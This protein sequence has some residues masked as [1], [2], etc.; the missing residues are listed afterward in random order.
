MKR[1]LLPLASAAIAGLLLPTGVPPA[2]A[3]TCAFPTDEAVVSDLVA[4][5]DIVAVA[6]TVATPRDS[7]LQGNL[8]VYLET[9][10][11][12]PKSGIVPLNQPTDLEVPTDHLRENCTYDVGSSLSQRYLLFLQARK[13]RSYQ[14]QGCTSWSMQY[15]NGY[16][17]ASEFFRAVQRVTGVEYLPSQQPLP[18]PDAVP[19]FLPPASEEAS[20]STPWLPI[21]LGSSLGATALLAASVLLLRLRQSRIR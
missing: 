5:T 7:P 20:S 3:C 8:H 13:D 1:F 9:T 4:K 18:S 17:N 2:Y 19:L 16:E 21:I 15:I 14:P 12:G 6:S 11:K 10:F